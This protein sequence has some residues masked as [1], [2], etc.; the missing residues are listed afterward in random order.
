[1]VSLTHSSARAKVARFAALALFP[2]FGLA[3]PLA[4]DVVIPSS[5]FASGRNAAEFHSDVR[6]F[7][8]STSPVMFTPVFYDQSSSETITKPAVTLPGRSQV[9]YDNVL[10]SLFGRNLGSFGPIRF[11]TSSP[12]VVSSS[13]NNVNG[14]GNGSVS[15][16]WLPGIDVQGA[17]KSGTLV[18]LAVSA[19]GSQGYRT[20]VD[21]IN[22]GSI[23]ANVTVKVRKGDG[24]QLSSTTLAPI[25]PNGFFQRTLDDGG[26]FPGVAGTTDTNLWVEF[27]SDQPVLAFA[28]VISNASGDPFAIVMTPEIAPAPVAPVAS[29]TVSPS[30]PT[31][32]QQVTFTDT[33]TGDP[34][35]QL[36]LF[37]DGSTPVTS[38]TSVTHAYAA[39]GTYKATHSVT[40]A[41]GIDAIS[42]DVV[43]A[44]SSG[45]TEI[46]ITAHQWAYEPGS[47]TLQVGK[48][49]KI[50][51]TSTD[52]NHGIGGLALLGITKCDIITKTLPCT[53]TITPTAN[54]IGT[55]D[56]I[57]T[58]SSCGAGHSN[59][60]AKIIVSN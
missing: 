51:W 58:Q 26:T 4:A 31:I 38:G 13:V 59:M 18:Q 5:A 7:N 47:I 3:F 48:T 50:T 21:F 23:P 27:A 30:S 35:T 6:V 42:K 14:C 29:F 39:A 16:Q 28:S 10:S 17:L 19:D 32:N 1:M 49:Y 56:Y 57:C 9:A 24:S 41:A 22:P 60:T 44:G 55:Y 15:G 8:P 37:G 53:A 12:L 33:S 2:A 36:W 45:P 34:A 40:N 25:G 43:V 11:Q 46:T 54:Q 52:V 20:N